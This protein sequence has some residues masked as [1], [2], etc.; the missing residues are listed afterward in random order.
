MVL[1]LN[2]AEA[3][4]NSVWD[5]S[6]N[7]DKHCKDKFNSADNYGDTSTGMTNL[8]VVCMARKNVQVLPAKIFSGVGSLITSVF[9]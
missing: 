6:M 9:V 8:T 5:S 2:Q 3:Q 1:S 4:F 7:Y